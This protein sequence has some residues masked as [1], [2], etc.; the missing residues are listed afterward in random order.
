MQARRAFAA[1]ERPPT[2]VPMYSMG[3]DASFSAQLHTQTH[4][5]GVSAPHGRA[6]SILSPAQQQHSAAAG[7]GGAVDAGAPAWGD[8]SGSNPQHSSAFAPT[9]GAFTGILSPP[10]PA[11]A[12]TVLLSLASPRRVVIEGGSVDEGFHPLVISADGEERYASAGR[13]AAHHHV[14]SGMGGGPPADTGTGGGGYFGHSS[15][16]TSPIR[17]GFNAHTNDND[18]RGHAQW[19]GGAGTPRRSG[20]DGD[21]DDD[22][23]TA[24]R[25]HYASPKVLATFR[26][27]RGGED[28]EGTGAGEGAAAGHSNRQS[29]AA[30][31]SADGAVPRWTSETRSAKASPPKS[32]PA[33]PASYMDGPTPSTSA[34]AAP[35]PNSAGDRLHGLHKATLARRQAS[36][37]RAALEGEEA[38][39]RASPFA[40][41]INRRGSKAVS[42]RKAAAGHSSDVTA[43]TSVYGGVPYH[44]TDTSAADA[45]AAAEAVGNRDV[46]TRLGVDT[47]R[48]HRERRL[49]AAEAAEEAE[50]ARRRAVTPLRTVTRRAADEAFAA[51]MAWRVRV[52]GRV[53]ALR[54]AAEAEERRAGKSPT[55]NAKSRAMAEA[56]ARRRREGA[57][58]AAEGAGATEVASESVED[59][60]LSAGALREARRQELLAR[61]IA[62]ERGLIGGGSTCPSASAAAVSASAAADRLYG[63]A[64]E[65]RRRELEEARANLF[66]EWAAAAAAGARGRAGSR[67]SNNGANIGAPFEPRLNPRSSALVPSGPTMAYVRGEAPA[68]GA[69]RGHATRARSSTG[70]GGGDHSSADSANTFSH[71]PAQNP[72][73]QRKAQQRLERDGLAHVPA[74]ERLSA[75]GGGRDGG[76]YAERPLG[77]GVAVPVFSFTPQLNSRSR[78]LDSERTGR[79]VGALAEGVGGGGT[80]DSF[81]LDNP[82]PPPTVDRVVLLQQSQRAADR[83]LEAAREARAA[84]EEERLRHIRA[85]SVHSSAAA[86]RAAEAGAGAYHHHADPSGSGSVGPGG[87]EGGGRQQKGSFEERLSAWEARRA[88]RTEQQRAA[89]A[90]AEVADCTFAPRITK[91]PVFVPAA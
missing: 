26:F 15:F 31:V 17:S 86:A 65:R 4:A 22:V 6:T 57:V 20:G 2:Y 74:H 23:I 36:A 75:Q 3:G 70:G 42:G 61:T 37:L 41:S 21:D 47:P 8:A 85:Q 56:A 58:G 34:S 49:L 81:G 77:R 48:L 43:N 83:R 64:E 44:P 87:E 1:A 14:S 40:P 32:R 73:S 9:F 79:M 11:P 82:F 78:A 91:A 89:R 53:D 27:S 46:F 30:H 35:P 63:D 84:A 28:N 51:Q 29:S 25:S 19:V 50:A 18:G 38:F 69:G 60:L 59:R 39:R 55:I 45:R 80:D 71:R 10:A 67:D 52:E 72:L 33:N 7:F 12:A 90:E 62:E 76:G 54:I 13:E 24:L 16:V 68:E 5:S 88:A 66:G